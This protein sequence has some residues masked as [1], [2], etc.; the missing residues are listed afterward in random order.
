MSNQLLSLKTAAVSKSFVSLS[1]PGSFG[2]LFIIILGLS[3]TIPA[4]AAPRGEGIIG[5]TPTNTKWPWM[6]SLAYAGPDLARGHFCG[7]TLI[8]PKF[9]LTSAHCVADFVKNP[10]A[11]QVILGRENLRDSTGTVV[12]ADGILLYPNFNPETLQNDLALIRLSAPVLQYQ[13]LG[14]LTA[15]E[16]QQLSPDTRALILGWGVTDP[17]IMIRPAQLQEAWIPIINEVQCGDRLGID[18]DPASMLC[19][20]ILSSTPNGTDGVDACYGDSGGPMMVQGPTGWGLLG[21]TSWG[22][23]CAS[24]RYWGI[25]LRAAAFNEWISSA[26]KNVLYAI[27]SPTIL[28]T[29]VVGRKLRCLPGV[30]HGQVTGSPQVR[31]QD[32]RSRRTLSKRSVYLVKTEDAGRTLNC[33]IRM[34]NLYGFVISKSDSVRCRRAVRL[35]KGAAS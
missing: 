4:S 32:V 30:F 33:Q 12:P 13:P 19:A 29:P 26:L 10:K 3:V 16:A 17:N 35:A 8:D 28:G 9:V 14:I 15:E 7:G 34:K 5:G 1:K 27:D 22:Y 23:L 18:F 20:G 24:D 31:W 25:Y 11:I 21:V 2:W 6:V